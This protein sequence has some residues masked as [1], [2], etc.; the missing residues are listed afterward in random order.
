MRRVNLF[1]FYGWFSVFF[2]VQNL[3]MFSKAVIFEQLEK[4]R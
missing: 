3:C 2:L 1:L 4:D